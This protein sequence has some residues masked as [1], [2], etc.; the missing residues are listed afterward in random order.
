LDQN[1]FP[2]SEQTVNRVETGFTHKLYKSLVTNGN[3]G[4]ADTSGSEANQLYF[5]NLSFDYHKVVPYGRLTGGAGIAYAYQNNETQ[6]TATQIVD[7][8]HTFVDGQPI[9]LAGNNVDPNSIIV[10]DTSNIIVYV[11][12]LDYTVTTFPTNVQ[13]N[14]VIG[15]RITDGQTV[16]IDYRLRP[17]PANQVSTLGYYATL[18]YDIEHGPLNGLGLY[19]RFA[20]QN[21]NIESDSPSTFIDNSFTDV[22]I[23]TDYRFWLMKV[24]VEQQWHDS[25]I[26][27]FDATRFFAR[28]D[29]SIG[30]RATFSLDSTYDI[31]DYK[32]DNNHVEDWITSATLRYQMTARL[33]GS[34]SVLYQDQ[35]DD[36]QGQTRG[37]E[38]Q[39]ELQ[40]RYRQTYLY[41]LLRNSNLETES[42]KTTFQFFE[43]GLKRD[44]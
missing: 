34:I 22:T 3:I 20:N 6:S 30:L 10:T 35:R 23:G 14:R 29:K 43:L 21:Q 7:Q 44:F 36:L 39:V 15:G 9:I 13:I 16:L 1:S 32:D 5:A 11:N 40:W 28:L 25:T 41:A 2:G 31:I 26:A 33:W 19:G 4:Y 27:P 37:W 12:G 17:Q 18:R 38:E 42:Q 8:P 24:G